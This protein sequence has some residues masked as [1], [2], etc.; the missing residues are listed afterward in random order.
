MYPAWLE[1]AISC[2]C[3]IPEDTTL[4]TISFDS[5]IRFYPSRQMF[6]LN[7]GFKGKTIRSAEDVYRLWGDH[8]RSYVITP[9]PLEVL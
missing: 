8:T 9:N 3:V 7:S 2:G 6:S 4:V 5:A 1:R